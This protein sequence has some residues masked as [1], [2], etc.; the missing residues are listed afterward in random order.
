MG[1]RLRTEDGKVGFFLKVFNEPHGS[2]PRTLIE[3]R[4][5]TDANIWFIDFANPKVNKTWYADIE[6]IFTPDESADYDFGLSVHGT[7]QLFINEQLVVSN[8]EIQKPGSAFLGSGTV[9]EKSTIHLEQGHRYKLPVQ[10]GNAETSQLIQTGLVD[11][12]QGRVRIG[13]AVSLSRLQAI[14]DVTK[15]AAEPNFIEVR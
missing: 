11:F 2:S 13:S 8:M 4:H 3:E 15:L 14:A 9:E 12:G 7:G 10:W 6:G 5:L 1:S